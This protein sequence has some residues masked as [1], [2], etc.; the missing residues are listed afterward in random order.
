MT[1][2]PASTTAYQA[3]GLKEGEEY[4]FRVK[5]ANEEGQSEP[6]ES[7]MVTPIAPDMPPQ[8]DPK[9][10][11]VANVLVVV[12]LLRILKLLSNKLCLN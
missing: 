8:I 3:K 2:V 11:E 7:K 1:R 6:L 12:Y 9:V 4:Q 5:S 10:N